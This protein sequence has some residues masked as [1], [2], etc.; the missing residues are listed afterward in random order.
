MRPEFQKWLRQ[1]PTISLAPERD[2]LA[3]CR[4]VENAEG[5]LDGHFATDQMADL[6]AR[7]KY[8]SEDERSGRKPRHSIKFS[9]GANIREGTAALAGAVR[10]YLRFSDDAASQPSFTQSDSTGRM[11]PIAPRQARKVSSW[12][13]WQSPG[14]EEL[15]QL[16]KITIPYIRFLHPDIVRDIVKDNEYRHEEWSDRLKKHG[17]DPALYLWQHSPCAFPGVRRYAGAT[18]IAIY[19]GRMEATA[20]PESAIKLDD[21]DYPKHIWSFVFL[22][23]PFRKSGPSGYSL[24]HLVDH[25]HYKNRGQEELK[26]VGV[27]EVPA[28]TL[29][30]LY[31][32]VTNTVYMPNGLIRPTDFSFSLRNLIQRRADEIYGGFCKLLPPHLSIRTGESDAWSLGS[33]DWCEPVGTLEHVPAFLQYRNKQMEMLFEATH[34]NRP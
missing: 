14:N 4:R 23:T 5:D 34:H 27:D 10:L 26:H 12:P 20:R 33:F 13:E 8:S 31:T 29:F 24:A 17:I 18:E 2:A 9:N 6:L 21:N 22:G 7:L 3:R 25:K 1:C 30:G 15:L 32:S 11:K 16:A 28:Q 19:R